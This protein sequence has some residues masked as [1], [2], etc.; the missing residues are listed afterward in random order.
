MARKDFSR[1]SGNKTLSGFAVSD[2]VAI[3]TVALVRIEHL[4]PPL[5]TIEPGEADDEI[6]RFQAA[7]KRSAED[8]T[9]IKKNLQGISETA[10]E[11]LDLLLDAHLAMLKSSRLVGGVEK[12]I[13]EHNLSAVSAILHVF[14]EIEAQFSG[15]KDGYLAQRYED[16]SAVGQRLLRLLMNIP[17]LSL[18]DI[19]QGSVVFAEELTPA[20]TVQLD[21]SRMAGF[22]TVRG[23]AAGH[24]AIMAR[25]F[26]IP[27]VLGVAG[28]LDGA[29]SGMTAIVDAIEGKVIFEPS[30]EQLKEYRARAAMLEK[31]REHLKS[32]ALL[33]A[34]TKDGARLRLQANLDVP[35]ELPAILESGAE[36]IGLF[37]TEFLFMG[38]KSL[39]GEDEQARIMTDVVRGM[40]G[41][42]V[43]FRTLDIGGDKIARA[44]GDHLGAGANPS[45]GLRAIRLSLKEPELFR[46]QMRAILRAGAEGPIRILLPMV[47]TVDEV[48]AARKIINDCHKDLKKRKVACCDD[49]PPVGV[50][51]EIPAAALSSDSLASVA[52]FFSLGTNDLIQYTMAI[53][54]GND[55]VAFLYDP[56]NPSVL[57]LMEFTVQAALRAKIPVGICGEMAS[58]PAFTELLV[59]LGLRDMSMGFSWIPAI[60]AKIRTIRADAA[61]KLAQDVMDS[62][63]P[64]DIKKLVYRK[65]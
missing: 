43:T 9:S 63:N 26:N 41:R 6:A 39:P 46:T 12:Q 40:G 57:R 31:E 38:R 30:A 34:E 29:K 58:N 52:D 53:D 19:P 22:A 49:V 56:L 48:V 51:I 23:G 64:A 62:Y 7:L 25:S 60:K 17:Y 37:R 33:P 8:I 15:M 13:R 35:R 59:G 61:Q 45:L 44:L 24:T 32:Q 20:D 50:M 11:E 2:G 65:G 55:Q 5:K 4:R 47:T 42:E 36:G 10:E 28:L 16:V 21:F 3:G 14:D 54:R 1:N 27:A 18:A